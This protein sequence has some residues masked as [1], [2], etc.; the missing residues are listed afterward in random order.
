MAR[1]PS[2]R[3]AAR[4]LRGSTCV[5]RVGCSVR[6][7]LL[8]RRNHLHMSGSPCTVLDRNCD[9]TGLRQPHTHRLVRFRTPP[10]SLPSY[11]YTLF[12]F[13]SAS[14]LSHL[15]PVQSTALSN[16][17][18][19]GGAGL[20]RTPDSDS[21]FIRFG[22]IR[23]RMMSGGLRRTADALLLSTSQTYD[24]SVHQTFR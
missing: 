8:V 6:R 21:W 16:T 3:R 17:R 12:V 11:S 1:S 14:A 19:W 15:F 4:L 7:S 5:T 20:A 24:W 9:R 22:P 23:T 10:P 13:A 18:K 2:I